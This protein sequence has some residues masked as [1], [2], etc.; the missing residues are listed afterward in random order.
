MSIIKQK[1]RTIF[2]K[3]NNSKV[4]FIICGTQKGGTTALDFYLRTHVEVCMAIKKEVHYFDKDS[5]F[6][7]KKDTY[8]KYHKNFSPSLKHKIIGEATPIY[9][10]WK[11]SIERI[12]KYNP[13]MKLIII[14][15]D[16]THRAYSHWN[17]ETDKKKEKR[18]FHDSIKSEI[19]VLENGFYGNERI[20]SYVERGFYSIQIKRI[21]EYFDQN[22]V[23]VIQNEALRNNPLEVLNDLSFFLSISPF[24][25]I[26]HKEVHT[27]Q[28]KRDMNS[29]DSEL[30][31]NLY[32]DD[33]CDL[34]KLLG[35]NLSGWKN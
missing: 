12:R 21:F 8:D 24:E 29:V 3:K 26:E 31:K 2:K 33:I 30:L 1:I 13:M 10:Y 27:R 5:N 9:M 23:F 28:Y 34:E 16:P 6:E 17:M 18:S 32:H 25:N 35:W 11:N 20:I 22:Q 4:N 15:R 14:L 19:S 7:N